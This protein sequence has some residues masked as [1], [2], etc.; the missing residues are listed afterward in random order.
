MT[1][2]WDS[3]A[4]FAAFDPVDIASRGLVTTG[5]HLPYDPKLID[6]NS[7]RKIKSPLLFPP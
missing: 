1:N 7:L 3:N 6:A 2:S 5:F 4:P